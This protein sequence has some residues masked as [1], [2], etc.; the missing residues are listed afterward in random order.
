[1]ISFLTILYF[2]NDDPGIMVLTTAKQISVLDPEILASSRMAR[3]RTSSS[4]SI[5]VFFYYDSSSFKSIGFSKFPFC[6]IY[7]ESI[8]ILMVLVEYKHSI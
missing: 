7:Y 5:I 6:A 2:V 3:L 1:M 8:I 4:L